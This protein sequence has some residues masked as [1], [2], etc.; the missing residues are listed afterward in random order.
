MSLSI[1]DYFCNIT[2]LVSM[3]SKDP[4]HNV[5]AIVVNQNNV[6]VGTGYNGF[7]RGI[8]DTRH[9]WSRKP[10]ENGNTKYDFVI[11]AEINAIL[12]SNNSVKGCTLY[13]MLF[14]CLECTKYI[15]QAGIKKI[16]YMSEEANKDFKFD[17]AK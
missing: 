4:D 11:H 2:K 15:I 10:D 1:L 3:R 16:I 5:G 7:P 13:T 6:I 8:S 12:N 17:L 14:P 9:N